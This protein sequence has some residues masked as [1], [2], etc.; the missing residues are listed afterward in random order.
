M[1]DIGARD[2]VAR[3]VGD[4]AIGRVTARRARP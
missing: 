2:A 1:I 4:Q 3:N